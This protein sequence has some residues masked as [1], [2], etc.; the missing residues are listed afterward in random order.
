MDADIII[1][2]CLFQNRLDKKS[3]VV[4]SN[5]EDSCEL[6]DDNWEFDGEFYAIN[7]TLRP[8][9]PDMNI[10]CISQKEI[11]VLYDIY[12]QDDNKHC[13]QMMAWVSPY[14]NTIPIFISK[15]GNGDLYLSFTKE[16]KEDM[17]EANMTRLYVLPSRVV[18]FRG[19]AGRCYP[20]KGNAMEENRQ[21]CTPLFDCIAEHILEL[22][23]RRKG[24]DISI[25]DILSP[26]KTKD[27]TILIN[28]IILFIF[29]Y[30]LLELVNRNMK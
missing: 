11:K 29:T 16:Q 30:C 6:K 15:N 4:M 24:V 22:T 26:S 20:C 23:H 1:K 2:F 10:V 8:V 13:I 17:Y 5:S 7:P 19:E 21:N 14:P 27:N 12:N 9:L 3:R 28:C 25:I 18:M